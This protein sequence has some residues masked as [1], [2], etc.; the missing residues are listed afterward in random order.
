MFLHLSINGDQLLWKELRALWFQLSTDIKAEGHEWTS[1]RNQTG[2]FSATG[3]RLQPSCPL[4]SVRLSASWSDVLQLPAA[5]RSD[6]IVW[7]LEAGRKTFIRRS[8]RTPKHTH[9]H[10]HHPKNKQEETNPACPWFKRP[11]RTQPRP[12][13]N[14]PHLIIRRLTDI[15]CA[16][17]W[18]LR[19]SERDGGGRAS[20]RESPPPP[21]KHKTN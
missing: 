15:R 6:S 13:V 10:R 4:C 7:T 12:S 9:T 11:R 8:L 17:D 14:N 1:C 20:S 16:D 19:T 21:S 3:G 2:D 5:P 18:R